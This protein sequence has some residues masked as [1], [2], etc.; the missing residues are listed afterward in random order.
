M[1][2]FFLKDILRK[3]RSKYL[4]FTIF[5]HLTHIFKLDL[6]FIY[7][8][9]FFYRQKCIKKKITEELCL[10]FHRFLRYFFIQISSTDF[11]DEKMFNI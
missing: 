1:K 11:F 5:K 7:S 6:K 8:K 3:Y 9:L 2:D 10:F 4:E